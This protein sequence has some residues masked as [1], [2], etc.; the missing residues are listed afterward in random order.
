MFLYYEYNDNLCYVFLEVRIKCDIINLY[1]IDI[2]YHFRI[3]TTFDRRN[4]IQR[5]INELEVFLVLIIL[6]HE[7][8]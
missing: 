8:R 1:H 5:Q 3:I 7:F 2:T 4:R 6:Q